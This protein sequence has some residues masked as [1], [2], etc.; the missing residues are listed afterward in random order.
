MK[1]AQGQTY[2]CLSVDVV[3]AYRVGRSED[4]SQIPVYYNGALWACQTGMCMMGRMSRARCCSVLVDFTLITLLFLFLFFSFCLAIFS[5]FLFLRPFS[6]TL[7]LFLL[8]PTWVN[9]FTRPPPSQRNVTRGES[10]WYFGVWCYS[11]DIYPLTRACKGGGDLLCLGLC[12]SNFHQS[13]RSV[14]GSGG[15]KTSKPLES[16]RHFTKQSSTLIFL[17]LMRVQK[18]TN[19]EDNPLEFLFRS[20]LGFCRPLGSIRHYRDL[21]GTKSL[22]EFNSC[23]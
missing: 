9:P 14:W 3:V 1:V 16:A 19:D 10:K 6:V 5:A 18:R 12:E 8:C 2:A 11:S 22:K 17:C 21:M 13:Q 7:P 20:V 15:G 23:P 4:M